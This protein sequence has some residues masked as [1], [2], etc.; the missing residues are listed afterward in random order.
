VTPATPRASS[1]LLLALCF[2]LLA[3]PCLAA[4]PPEPVPEDLTLRDELLAG[5]SV[6]EWRGAVEKIATQKE[7]GWI[8]RVLGDLFLATEATSSEHHRSALAFVAAYFADHPLDD[9][10]TVLLGAHIVR[11]AYDDPAF[12]DALR[13]FV[14]AGAGGWA[15]LLEEARLA[16]DSEDMAVKVRGV[17]FLGWSEEGQ[18]LASLWRIVDEAKED[19]PR[20]ADEH[21]GAMRLRQAYLDAFEALVSYRFSGVARA[22]EQLEP[23]RRDSLYRIV[24]TLS[25]LKDTEESPVFLAWGKRLVDRAVLESSVE[26]L[27]EFL[28]PRSGVPMKL[29]LY[30]WQQ[31]ATMN[32]KASEAWSATLCTVLSRETESVILQAV[33]DLLRRMDFQEIPALAE[34]SAGCVVERLAG[35]DRPEDRERLAEILGHLKSRPHVHEALAHVGPGET[36]VIAALLRSL[37][38]V[39]GARAEDALERYRAQGEGSPAGVALRTAVVTALGHESMAQSDGKAA[40]DALAEILT[41]EGTLG[42]GRATDPGVRLEAIRSLRAHAS[43]DAARVLGQVAREPDDSQADRALTVLGLYAR[44]DASD[45]QPPAIEI[46]A[47]LAETPA[48]PHARRMRALKELTHLNGTDPALQHRVKGLVRGILV[49]AAAPADLRLQAAATATALA[50]ADAIEPLVDLWAEAPDAARLEAVLN[51]LRALA[52]AG[53][54]HDRRI[55]D[56]LLL[57]GPEDGRWK[58]A[59]SLLSALVEAHPRLAFQLALARLLLAQAGVEGRSPAERLAD[60]SEADRRLGLVLA[61]GAGDQLED[62]LGLRVAVLTELSGLVPADDTGLAAQKAHLLAAVI[63]AAQSRLRSTHELALPLIARLEAPPLRDLPWK[64]DEFT[65]F[66]QAKAEIESLLGS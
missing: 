53:G 30:A 29:R 57:L 28:V 22:V 14:T 17:R 3:A 46:L 11:R 33:L 63:A 54:A 13:G 12:V 5:T 52:A 32:P 2:V 37:G 26:D 51:L 1:R 62:V 45:A 6:G 40:R 66:R 44:R 55:A 31:A 65:R 47:G 59:S 10:K 19:L 34:R 15:R 18:A 21:G 36:R 9:G 39:T 43:A 60:L 4:D 38:A 16:L 64:D 35:R 8:E 61:A 42:L 49:D 27:V 50:D 23:L 7:R 56:R 24:A 48:V 41:G 25:R 58:E 20:L